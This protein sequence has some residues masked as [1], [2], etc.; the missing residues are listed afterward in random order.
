M[1]YPSNH[2]D[3]YC[4][5]PELARWLRVSER[6]V[7]RLLETGGGP[8]S[9]RLGRRIIFNR[10]T[11]QQWLEARTTGRTSP[12]AE[13]YVVPRAPIRRRQSAIHERGLPVD[14]ADGGD[15]ERS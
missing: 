12:S 1:G 9:I 5:L 4:T 2:D 13:G 8:P 15:H 14:H 6:H 3:E 7:Q 11:V 10:V